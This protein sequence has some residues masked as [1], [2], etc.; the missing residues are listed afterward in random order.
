MGETLGLLRLVLAIQAIASL[1][2]LDV[3]IDHD[4]GE[5]HLF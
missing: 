5:K 4:P 3:G 1:V 2:Y